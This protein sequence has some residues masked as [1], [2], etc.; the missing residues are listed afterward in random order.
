MDHERRAKRAQKV[1][2]VSLAA[3][4]DPLP[5]R[6]ERLHDQL[7]LAGATI[8]AIERVRPAEQRIERESRPDVR[9]LARPRLHRDLGRRD[10]Q[11]RPELTDPARREDPSRLE[12][13]SAV[14]IANV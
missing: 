2:P 4:S 11:H 13:H 14:P 6:P 3:R 5:A 7:D 10:T 1:Q 9:E 12:D 8:D